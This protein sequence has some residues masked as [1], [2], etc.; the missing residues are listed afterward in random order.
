MSVGSRRAGASAVA[1]ALALALPQGQTRRPETGTGLIVGQVLDGGSG[2]PVSGA[3]V[4]L[5]LAVVAVG[6]GASMGVSLLVVAVAPL[7]VIVGYETVGHRHQA[8][9]LESV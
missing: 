9:A 6:A 3:I 5:V 8:A 2:K 7:V 4:A 1:I